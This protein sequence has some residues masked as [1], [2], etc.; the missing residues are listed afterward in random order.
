M[1]LTFPDQAPSRFSVALRAGTVRKLEARIAEYA[2]HGL[3]SNEVVAATEAIELITMLGKHERLTRGHTERVRAYADLIAV[4]L[5]VSE[6]DRQKLAWAVLL[7][8][9]GKLTVPAEILN[10]NGRPSDAEWELLR[11]HPAAGEAFVAPLA[12]WLGS[13]RFATSQH[14][15]RWDG[16][17]YPK[18]IAGERITLAGRITAVADAYDVITSKRSYKNPI[19]AEDARKE[20]VACSGTQFDPAVVR[21]FLAVGI[22]DK[23]SVGFLGGL[24]ELPALA[25]IG[26]GITAAPAVAAI[27]VATL[28]TGAI[29]QP[30]SSELA[31]DA[32]VSTISPTTITVPTTDPQPII[33]TSAPEPPEAALITTSTTTP[34]TTT[35][36]TTTAP[37]TTAAP[38]TS[39][40]P[41]PSAVNDTAEVE[42]DDDEKIKVLKNDSPGP[43]GSAIDDDTLRIV[44]GPRHGTARVHDDHV[45]YQASE[46]YEGVDTLVYEICDEAGQC[47]TATVT[48]TVDD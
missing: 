33:A 12:D 26:A 18:G 28:T 2:E 24:M 6:E 8:D 14:H 37:T 23:R 32:P 47:S 7:H 40:S 39:N 34:S 36:L 13:W 42:E 11:N 44:Q 46:D 17:G 4:E 3:N 41:G 15:E 16:K 27:T 45:R 20:L 48:I 1:S 10:K 9:I 35:P 30:A 38:T 29:V 22:E 5:G 31:L 25:N 19:S 43:S 21:A